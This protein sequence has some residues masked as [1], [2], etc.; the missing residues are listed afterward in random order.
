M[1]KKKKENKI[2]KYG[3]RLVLAH[4][5]VPITATPDQEPYEAGVI[6]PVMVGK[7]EIEEIVID[8]DLMVSVCPDCS[9]VSYIDGDKQALQSG[10]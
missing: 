10:K 3:H 6:E 2:K 4:I 9:W 5:D 7:E 1:A 8:D